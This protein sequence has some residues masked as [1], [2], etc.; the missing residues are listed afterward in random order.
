MRMNNMKISNDLDDW[1][2]VLCLAAAPECEANGVRQLNHE[3]PVLGGC[4]G[5]WGARV[6]LV[7]SRTI[8]SATRHANSSWSCGWRFKRRASRLSRDSRRAS[9]SG[10]KSA[11]K[12]PN[13]SIRPSDS[14]LLKKTTTRTPYKRWCRLFWFNGQAI[15]LTHLVEL[16]PE[17]SINLLWTLF[18]K[19][20]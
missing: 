5:G 9:G 4:S 17:K 12:R 15:I 11:S 19:C 14:P 1:C 3:P 16:T 6:M 2:V 8:I 18:S 20:C 7:T 10:S 13:A